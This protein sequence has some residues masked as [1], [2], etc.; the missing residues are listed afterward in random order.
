MSR[1]VN[2]ALINPYYPRPY[3]FTEAAQ[4]LC[5]SIRAAGYESEVQVNRVDRDQRCLVLGALPAHYAAVEQLDRRK[6]II[7]N[8]EQLEGSPLVTGDTYTP[9]LRQW[10]VADYHANNVAWLRDH[11]GRQRVFELPI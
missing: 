4:C 11:S 3:T 7:V 1:I 10:L 6:A 9:W 2:V 8:F 5:D